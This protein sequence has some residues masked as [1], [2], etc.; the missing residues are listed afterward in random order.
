MA[1]TIQSGS[2]EEKVL[3]FIMKKYPVT[4]RDMARTLSIKLDRVNLIL[5]KFEKR[6]IVSLDVLPDVWYVRLARADIRFVG[7]NP[8]QQKKLKHKKTKKKKKLLKKR[9]NYDG[10]MYQ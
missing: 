6:G 9:D 10:M 4:N 7:S 1:V 5:M 3:R 2:E 8:T